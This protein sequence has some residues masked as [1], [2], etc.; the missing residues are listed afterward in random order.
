MNK[1]VLDTNVLVSSLLA[2]GSPAA[3]VDLT[4]EGKLRPFYNDLIISEYWHVLK[5]Q[6]FTFQPLQ[7]SRLINDIVK[8][9]IAIEPHG[10]SVIPMPDEDD[11]I[12][13]EVAK[14]SGAILITG[15]LRHFPD[16]SFIM[17]PSDFFQKYR[18]DTVF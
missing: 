5:R 17:T 9:G 4:A 16:E 13:Y 2:N 3:I 14:A 11:R 7:V 6:K 12:F 1:V 18:Q 8:I 15:K 10:L